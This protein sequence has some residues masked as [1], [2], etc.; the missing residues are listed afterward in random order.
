LVRFR[1]EH[2]V[3]SFLDRA[4]NHL[5]KMIP[6]TTLIDLDNLAHFLVLLIVTHPIAP[7]FSLKG[8][9]RFKS[10]KDSL[11]YHRKPRG[12][13]P[14]R[15]AS[16]KAELAVLVEAGP[17]PQSDGVARWRRLD[18]KEVIRDRA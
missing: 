15:T 18:L 13:V 2:G 4:T 10:A 11:R 14:K 7:S 6:N 3:Q 1:I 12:G 17:D 8:A 9:V 5:T 16:Q